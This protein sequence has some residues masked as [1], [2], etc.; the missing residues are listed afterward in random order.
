M[1]QNSNGGGENGICN[2][3]RRDSTR[4]NSTGALANSLYS[5]SVLEQETTFCLEELQDNK[6]EPN[7]V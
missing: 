7:N 4:V 6:L 5:D 1:S 3:W 2:S